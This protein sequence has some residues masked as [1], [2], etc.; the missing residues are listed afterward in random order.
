MTV[1]FLIISLFIE[2]IV[3]FKV[4]HHYIIHPNYWIGLNIVPV[5]LAAYLLNG[6]ALTFSAGIYI[7]KKTLFLPITTIISAITNVVINILLIPKMG[8]MGAAIATLL[9]YL[10]MALSTFYFSQKIYPIQYELSRILIITLSVFICLIFFKILSGVI[11]TLI[12]KFL[13]VLLFFGLIYIFKLFSSD[14][15]GMFKKYFNRSQTSS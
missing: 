8:I 14:E 3:K 10:V 9:S 1:V 5:V 15:I 7:E 2:D 12:L 11:I 4:L 13:T 6:L